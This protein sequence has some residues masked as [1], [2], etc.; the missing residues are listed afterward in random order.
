MGGIG[1]KQ[2]GMDEMTALRLRFR[3]FNPNAM[4]FGPGVLTDTAHLPGDFDAGPPPGDA[5]SIVL[6]FL[7]DIDRRISTDTRQ[8]ITEVLVERLEPIRQRDRGAALVV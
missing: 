6:D 2:L 7:S 4:H 1:S 5:E 3:F 8:L